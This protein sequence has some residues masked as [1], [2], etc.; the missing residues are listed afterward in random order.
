MFKKAHSF[1]L[2]AV[3]ILAAA[4]A[5]CSGNTDTASGENGS[6]KTIKFMHLW[7]AGSSKQQ[8]QIVTDIIEQYEAEHEDVKIEV[9]V[10]ENEQYKNK[11]KVLSS[12]NELPDVGFTWAA[13]YMTPF[14]KGNLF[15][16]LDDVLNDGLKDSF[17]SGT[18][19]AY[20]LDG[21]TYGL[22]LELNIAPIYYNKEI[23]KKYNLD[24]PQTY[25]EFENAVKTLA[26]NGV[27]PIALG[28][29]DRWTGSLWYMYL[30]DRFGGAE[31]LNKAIDRSGSFEDPA[32]VSAAEEIQ[33]LVKENAFNKGYN[34]LS[35][36]EGKAEFLNGNA[37][38]Y[39][40]GTWELPN[41]TTNEEIP[42][43]FRDSVGFFKFPTVDGGKG[44]IDSWVGGPGVGL[45]VA[46]NS[47]VKDESKEFVK[48]FVKKW[49]EQSVEKA[50]VIP[51]TKV[52]TGKVDLPDLYI[53]VLNEL[54]KASSLTLFAD[55]QMSASVAE[56]HLNLIQSLFGNEVK[57]ADYAK[58]HEEALKAEE[59]N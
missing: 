52:D 5:G 40:M 7:P 48:F 19:E 14:V 12:S 27:A 32:L 10:L 13:G 20:A 6:K 9:E 18:T 36:D 33:N 30:A 1:L 8:N 43:D 16:E 22:P 39:L 3:L 57:P 2:I 55:V 26:D 29:K 41:F 31:V 23:F 11:I 44:N 46:E 56:T 50:G 25:S 42:Q 34:G 54:N 17:V 24:V 21:K 53:D 45:F 37:A 15:A 4:L 49:G 51:A 28:N 59:G 47:K 35:N 58:Q 38:M